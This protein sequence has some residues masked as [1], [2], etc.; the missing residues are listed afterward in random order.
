MTTDV[1]GIGRGI[2]L[3]SILDGVETWAP[4]CGEYGIEGVDG[5]PCP[6]ALGSMPPGI[7]CIPADIAP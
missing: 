3:G 2:W 4:A 7:G 5:I 6:R 1:S